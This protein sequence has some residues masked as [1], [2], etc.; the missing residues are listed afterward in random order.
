MSSFVHKKHFLLLLST[1]VCLPVSINNWWDG[2]RNFAN[3]FLYLRLFR[4]IRYGEISKLWHSSLY[5][6]IEVHTFKPF[7]SI[8]LYI[9]SQPRKEDIR[10]A[11]FYKKIINQSIFQKRNECCYIDRIRLHPYFRKTILVLV[12]LAKTCYGNH[13]QCWISSHYKQN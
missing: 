10:T 5:K 11:Q 9:L 3:E 7:L 1:P 2:S 4:L 13:L 12:L 6:T 8:Y